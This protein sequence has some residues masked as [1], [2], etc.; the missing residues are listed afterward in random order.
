MCLT[1][2]VY[3]SDGSVVL[4]SE[5]TGTTLEAVGSEVAGNLIAKGAD[6]LLAS[7]RRT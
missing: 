7:S 2:R 5:R 6:D 4:S 1:G 3:A